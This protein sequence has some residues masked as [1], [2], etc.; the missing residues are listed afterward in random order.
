MFDF[1]S[2]V[3]FA[4]ILLVIIIA[5][6]FLGTLIEGIYQ[7]WWFILI[8]AT[9]SLNLLLCTLG[10]IRVKKAKLGFLITHGAILVI[11]AGSMISAVWGVRGGLQLSKGETKGAFLTEKGGKDLGFK[12]RLDDFS[13]EWYRQ[14]KYKLT[15]YVNDKK[16]QK[17]YRVKANKEYEIVGTPYSFSV[18][19]YIPDFFMEQKGI[20]K[21][22]SEQPNNPAVLVR[23]NKGVA[24]EERWVFANHPHITASWDE[25]IEFFYDSQALVKEYR[26]LVTIIDRGREVLT[27]DIKVNSPLKYRGYTFYQNSY[28]AK[29]LSWT[30][31]EVSSDPGV[32]PVFLGFI[33]LN[34]GIVISFHRKIRIK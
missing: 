21:S 28:D 8:L 10:K 6:S 34:L 3:K 26:S 15:V 32:T 17:V 13:V 12:V 5:A 25:N 2:S 4:L 18:V 19:N 20:V 29:K 22:K 7:S 27:R 11:L 24:Q 31:L 16:L 14:D 1:L 30:L 23:I 9:F 33:L